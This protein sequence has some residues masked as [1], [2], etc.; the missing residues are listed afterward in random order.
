MESLKCNFNTDRLSV[1]QVMDSS[2]TI[3]PD[4]IIGILSPEVTESLP[5]GWQNISS[6]DSASDWLEDRLSESSVLLIK[7]TDDEKSIGFIFLYREEESPFEIRFGYLLH[8]DVWG[9]GLGTEVLNGFIKWC[10]A[11]GRIK[12]I[13]GGVATNNKGSIRVLEKLGFT[14]MEIEQENTLFYQ[15]KLKA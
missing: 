12:S 10:R 8:K 14:Q 11:D 5:P 4:K 15:Y 3:A 1:V 13:D 9:K 7:T 2:Q 6:E